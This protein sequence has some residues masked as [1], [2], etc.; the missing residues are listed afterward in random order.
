MNSYR[1]V[2]EKRFRS[3]F[4]SIT[5]FTFLEAALAIYFLYLNLASIIILRILILFLDRT[6]Y[7][8]IVKN[9]KS[10][11]YDLRVKYII[12][13]FFISKIASLFFFHFNASLMIISI[14]TRLFC[15]VSFV[16]QAV[17]LS[18]NIIIFP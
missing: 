5:A 7:F 2:D 8:L 12:V 4:S 17:K 15:T 10:L 9:S 14:F 16:I 11:L 6:V 1:A 13:I 18:T 3:R